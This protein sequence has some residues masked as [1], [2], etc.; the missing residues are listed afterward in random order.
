MVRS[1]RDDF[2][3]VGEVP[4][5]GACGLRGIQGSDPR[6]CQSSLAPLQSRH[7]LVNAVL[8][9]SDPP[10]YVR[11]RTTP[12]AVIALIGL[13]NHELRRGVEPVAVNKALVLGTRSCSA[14]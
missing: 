14:R 13:S 11:E 5:R 1:D 10:A 7:V 12:G 4:G 2:V 9:G 3:G 8:F 6:D